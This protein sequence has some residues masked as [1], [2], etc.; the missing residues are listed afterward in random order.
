M[1]TNYSDHSEYSI[2]EDRFK[3]VSVALNIAAFKY[4]VALIDY[5]T[6]PE[7]VNSRD[8]YLKHIK[9]YQEIKE[10]MITYQ[11]YLYSESLKKTTSSRCR[12]K[13]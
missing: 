3:V 13:K 12:S 5:K 8:V 11:N 9:E 10:K 4:Q 7:V 1:D 6:G 2:V